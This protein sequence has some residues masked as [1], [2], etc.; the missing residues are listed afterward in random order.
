MQTAIVVTGS[1]GVVSS[2]IIRFTSAFGIAALWLGCALPSERSAAAEQAAAKS[3]PI[4]TLVERLAASHIWKNGMFPNLGLPRTASTDEV[5]ARVFD[6][7]SFQEGRAKRYR[8]LETRR[9]QIS[10][11]PSHPNTG[12]SRVPESPYY[13]Y[14]AALVRTDVGDKI[15]LLKFE[16]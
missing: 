13:T 10:P 3:D 14:I 8:I 4:A 7:T 6:L 12:G 15:V 2:P 16:D 11:N 5:I 1:E 9:V